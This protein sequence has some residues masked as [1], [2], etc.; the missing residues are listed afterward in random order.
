M[1]V[2]T[3]LG[4]GE[5]CCGRLWVLS[6]QVGVDKGLGFWGQFLKRIVNRLIYECSRLRVPSKFLS[7]MQGVLQDFQVKICEGCRTLRKFTLASQE[8]QRVTC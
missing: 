6:L 3:C 4:F 2:E 7:K 5:L 1:I 8:L